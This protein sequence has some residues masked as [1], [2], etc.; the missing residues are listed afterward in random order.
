MI[1][2]S[3]PV[4]QP[5]S[6]VPNQA[7][8]SV[9]KQ[10]KRDNNSN[11]SKGDAFASVLSDSLNSDGLTSKK[12]LVIS[13]AGP[14]Q[15]KADSP[16]D[17]PQNG[18]SMA[19][20]LAGWLP[21]AL[22]TMQG[23]GGDGV[24]SQSVTAIT[25]TLGKTSGVGNPLKAPAVTIPNPLA[26]EVL[27]GTGMPN[28]P[29]DNLTVTTFSPNT[30]ASLTT[31]QPVQ[32]SG[33]M[34]A[35]VTKDSKV[36]V[37]GQP[38]TQGI[39]E[40]VEL[41]EADLPVLPEQQNVSQKGVP[42]PAE[43]VKVSVLRQDIF[44]IA[45]PL[46]DHLTEQVA[47]NVVGENAASVQN[48]INQQMPIEATPLDA[49]G[50]VL[51][52]Q[53]ENSGSGD[54]S[55]GLFTKKEETSAKIIDDTIQPAA[56]SSVLNQ[57]VTKAES[58]G[59]AV[60]DVKTVSVNDP[61]NVAGQIVEQAKVISRPTNSEMIIKLKPEHLG[62]L[63]LKI[64][65]ENGAVSASFLTN[66]AEVRNA[67]ESSLPQ[68]RQELANQGLKV[69]QVGVYASLNQSFGEPQQQQQHY[70][71]NR[72]RRTG[73]ADS[74]DFLAAADKVS[75]MTPTEEGVDYRI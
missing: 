48:A 64:V 49:E 22:M 42:M 75:L 35:E 10:A 19:A 1:T 14:G 20:G 53:T 8:K 67:I 47:G 40:V 23:Q 17:I 25:D 6:M 29:L 4:Q 30:I 39:A 62:E 74:Q 57:H 2:M 45:G 68:L 63:T 65:V 46:A 72:K 44:P 7:V 3:M 28:L 71:E 32:S 24:P 9:G 60:P 52:I 11:Q 70:Q 36:P 38:V 37:L 18:L 27:T 56:F 16:A 12:D 59:A 43:K 66:H 51:P 58:T 41:M 21:P 54:I 15:E 34:G 5:D 61:Y 26:Q 31:Q 73:S 13:Q 50:L 33:V 69:D 55:S